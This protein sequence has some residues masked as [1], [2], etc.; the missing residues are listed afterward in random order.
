MSRFFYDYADG[1]YAED[2][3]GEEH[4][5]LPAAIEAARQVAAELA[6]NRADVSGRIVLKNE[7]GEV[8]AEVPLQPTATIAH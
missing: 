2:N 4:P 7:R 3:E 5:D 1:I 8:I 6:R